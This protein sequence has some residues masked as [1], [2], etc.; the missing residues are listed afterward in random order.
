VTFFHR[1]YKKAKIQPQNIYIFKYNF[2]NII[3]DLR[4]PMCVSHALFIFYLMT[5]LK[6]NPKTPI[7]GNTLITCVY[8]VIVKLMFHH[9][10]GN[11]LSFQNYW[12]NKTR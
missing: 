12:L 9:F 6:I 10:T 3:F 2:N 4:Y 11:R 5:G 1:S 7:L 8:S